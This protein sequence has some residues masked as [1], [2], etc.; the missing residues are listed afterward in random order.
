MPTIPRLLSS[1][2]LVCLLSLSVHAQAPAPEPILANQNRVA[3]G[4]L[5]SGILNIQLELRSGAWRPE[6]EDG[7]QLFVQAFAEA[8]SHRAQIPGPLL[9]MPV[10]TTVHASVT[11][12]LKIKATVYGFN[13]RPADPQQGGTEISPGESHQFT[14]PVGAP[15]T[16]YYW[17]RTTEPLKLATR[18]VIEPIRADAQL[19]G[20]FI[21]DPADTPVS[22]DRIFVINSMFVAADIIHPPVEVLSINGK[23]YPYTEPLAHSDTHHV[24]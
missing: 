23:S 8:G 14:F 10:G 2:V 4:K 17:A 21:V 13:T 1:F 11:N 16:Y 9:R 19:N 24:H 18:T 5:E 22:P 6:A 3:A 12:K 7:P 20:A 15:G